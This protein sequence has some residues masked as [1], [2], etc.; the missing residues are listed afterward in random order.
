MTEEEKKEF[1]EFLKWKEENAKKNKGEEQKFSNTEPSQNSIHKEK[2]SSENNVVNNSKSTTSSGKILIVVA[3]FLFI[4]VLTIMISVGS[5]NNSPIVAEVDSLEVVDTARFTENLYETSSW[6]IKTE[7]DPI[8]DAENIWA[9][10]MSDN[11]SEDDIYGAGYCRITVRYMKKYGYDALISL[12]RG[13]IYGSSYRNE[14]YVMVR[15]DKEPAI[16]YWFDESADGSSST[17]FIRKHRDFTTRCKKA[18][19]IKVEVPIFQGGRPI[20]NF[21]VK[22]PLV[23]PK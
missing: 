16:K 12:T 5:K 15:F 4:L 23:W 1:E 19:S 18:K 2:D 22:K 10:V 17:V 14:N 7:K 21:E 6:E 13:Q 20:F 9:T 11:Y 3:I 8:T